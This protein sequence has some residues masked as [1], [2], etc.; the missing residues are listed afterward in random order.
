MNLYY[1]IL[2]IFIKIIYKIFNIEN[3]TK[4]INNIY[5]GNFISSFYANENNYDIIINVSK[6]LPFF[7]NKINIR[8]PIDDNYIFKNKD[9]LKFIDI[10]NLI[11]NIKNKKILIHCRM[12]MQRSCFITQ[13]ILINKYNIS[14]NKSFKLIKIKRNISFLPYH[15]FKHIYKIK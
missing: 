3:T 1:I 12:G 4:I 14:F 2:I 7:T 6:E 13:L 5:I 8:I 9:L 15:N 10:I 11:S